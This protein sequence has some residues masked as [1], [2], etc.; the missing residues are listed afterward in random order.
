M[1]VLAE[2]RVLADMGA[3]VDMRVLVD[4]MVRMLPAEMA[5]EILAVD[6]T[7]TLQS[8]GENQT[9]DKVPGFF[10]G[11][12]QLARNRPSYIDVPDM[13]SGRLL[14]GNNMPSCIGDFGVVA[15]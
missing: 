7:V 2:M 3:L 11:R 6:M 12:S 10:S 5:H 14:L 8:N 1:R 4:L 13:H 9:L 15:S